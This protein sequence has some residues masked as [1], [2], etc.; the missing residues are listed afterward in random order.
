MI[1]L[2]GNATIQLNLFSIM[3]EQVYTDT[4]QGQA[5]MNTITWLLKNKNFEP[6]SSGLYVY[7][8]Q[9]NN[10]PT[11]VTETGKVLVFH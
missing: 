9:T 7:V 11:Q 6:V 2:C 1:N 3:G 5:G 8:I 4:I 10:G